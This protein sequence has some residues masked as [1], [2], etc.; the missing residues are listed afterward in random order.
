MWI[1]E[2][3]NNFKKQFKKLSPSLQSKTV[4]AIS[5]LCTS[6]N[7]AI[8]GKYKKHMRIYAYDLDRKYR[9]IYDIN[10]DEHVISFIRVGDHKNAY[11]K[12]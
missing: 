5:E 9:I 10:Y 3:E 4:K 12:D 6:N 7:P 11:G 1:P 8:L 2:R